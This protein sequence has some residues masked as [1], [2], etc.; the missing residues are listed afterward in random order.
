[1]NS[2]NAYYPSL[3]YHIL[4]LCYECYLTPSLQGIYL[5][6]VILAVTYQQRIANAST[7]FDEFGAIDII[8]SSRHG[9][10]GTDM[11]FARQYPH[12]DD[13]SSVEAVSV[14]EAMPQRTRTSYDR[15]GLSPV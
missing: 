14:P 9:I 13:Q 4:L 11:I 5:T 6:L 12:S 1:M 8:A 7:S 15:D 3:R 2:W 10:P